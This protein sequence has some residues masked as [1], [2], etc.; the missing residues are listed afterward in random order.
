MRWPIISKRISMSKGCW[1]WRGE[2]VIVPSV[3]QRGGKARPFDLVA[4]QAKTQPARP[5]REHARPD[6][7]GSKSRLRDH[8]IAG[9][10][11]P[12]QRRSPDQ[13]PALGLNE[14]V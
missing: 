14:T 3:R 5:P 10:I 7:P 13:R 6:P 8:R 9:V 1:R 12:E 11:E 4:G 2:R